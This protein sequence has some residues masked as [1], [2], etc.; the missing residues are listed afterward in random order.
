MYDPCNFLHYLMIN[1]NNKF[2]KKNTVLCVRYPI[3]KKNNTLRQFLP[4]SSSQEEIDI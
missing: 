2:T 3:T 4:S 1:N